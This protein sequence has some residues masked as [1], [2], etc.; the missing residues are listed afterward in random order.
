MKLIEKRNFNIFFGILAFFIFATF[1]VFTLTGNE[2]LLKLWKLKKAKASL[3]LKNHQLLVENLNLR[4][5]AIALQNL[6]S[7]EKQA[8]ETLGFVHPDEIIFIQSANLR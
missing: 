2:G 6:S 5:E 4:Q 7:L 1:C 8:R 3:S